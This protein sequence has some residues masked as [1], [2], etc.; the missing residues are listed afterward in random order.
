VIRWCQDT[1]PGYRE[2]GYHIVFNLTGGFKSIQGWMQT[3]GMFYADEIVYIFETGKELLPGPA[4]TL[5]S[6]GKL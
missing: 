2:S 5:G 4:R 1:L 3:L 6:P